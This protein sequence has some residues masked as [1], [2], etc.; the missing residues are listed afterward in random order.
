MNI[1][2]KLEENIIAISTKNEKI[3]MTI[4]GKHKTVD[5]LRNL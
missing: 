2:F 5:D 3:F 1:T 4:H